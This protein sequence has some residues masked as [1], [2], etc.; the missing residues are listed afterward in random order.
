LFRIKLVILRIKI[1]LGRVL[2]GR[3][4]WPELELHGRRHEELIREG[5]EAEGEGA[6]LGGGSARA[7]LCCL[8]IRDCLLYVREESRKEEGEE[9]REKRKEEG[10]EKRKGK[11][12]NNF[13]TWKFLKK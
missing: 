13:Q 6:R 9:K 8:P 7:A 12:G 2:H 3:Q 11:N 4:S 5:R 1:A 10:K